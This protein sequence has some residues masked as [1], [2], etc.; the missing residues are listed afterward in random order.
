MAGSEPC[1]M[2]GAVTDARP[3]RGATD[4]LGRNT[5]VMAVGTTLSRITGFGRVF[6]LGYALG[7]ARLGDAYNLANTVPNIVYDLVLGGVLSAPL[8][9]VFVTRL[10]Q[11][12]EDD[13]WRAI[14]AVTSA[15]IAVLVV[16]SA[17]FVL[18][19]PAVINLYTV[20]NH[21]ES[22]GPQR[23]VATTLLRWF[24]P[25]V[26]LL[27]GIALTTAILNARRHFAVPMFSPILNNLITIG[28]L[29][30]TPRVA[31]SLDLTR[32]QH[33]AL[34]LAF[35][36]IGTTLGY[37]AQ[38]W[39]QLPWLRRTKADVRWVWDLRHPAVR[40][41]LSLSTWTFGFV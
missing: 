18:L 26:F 32:I 34:A 38:G 30:L 36:G 29:L 31:D 11:D 12:G 28:V 39:V 19:A 2:P 1:E 37:L 35:L 8:V 27:G 5:A 14:S 13:G 24:A 4:T 22:A 17:A 33:D 23:A 15:A 7:F 10:E 21:T 16:L 40:A 41:V 3:A 20:L 25:Q 6:A 9:P